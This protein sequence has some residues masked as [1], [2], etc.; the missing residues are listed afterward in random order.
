M[1]KREGHTYES[2]CYLCVAN[3]RVLQFCTL[4]SKGTCTTCD[5][6]YTS[7]STELFDRCYYGD[8]KL[9]LVFNNIIA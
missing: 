9:S 8:G 3:R 1:R 7:N 2:T 4:V 6:Y 5:I